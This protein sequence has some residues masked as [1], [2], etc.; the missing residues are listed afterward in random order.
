MS[1]RT[2]GAKKG[3]SPNFRSCKK[4]IETIRAASQ[5]G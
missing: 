5:R 2:A 3:R 4:L 1:Q